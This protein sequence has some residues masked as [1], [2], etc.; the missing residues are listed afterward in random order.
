MEADDCRGKPQER[1]TRIVIS[2][3]RDREDA[4]VPSSA[5]ES[6]KK[7]ISESMEELGLKATIESSEC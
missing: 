4:A 5:L 6:I 1:G 3:I 7:R 2:S